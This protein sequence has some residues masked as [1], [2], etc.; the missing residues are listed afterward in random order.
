MAVGEWDRSEDAHHEGGNQCEDVERLTQLFRGRRD[1][2]EDVIHDVEARHLV[3][4]AEFLDIGVH[5]E[6][7][8]AWSYK[9]H[10]G[11]ISL[12]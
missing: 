8:G 10:V 4:H 7:L 11:D 1:I 2:E 9:K 3:D 6:E 5:V 12:I